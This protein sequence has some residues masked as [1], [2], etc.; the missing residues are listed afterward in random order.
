M[1]LLRFHPKSIKI[2]NT[3]L[4]LDVEESNYYIHKQKFSPENIIMHDILSNFIFT[5]KMHELKLIAADKVLS[6]ILSLSPEEYLTKIINKHTNTK[7]C[8]L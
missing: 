1:D 5:K 3:N 6:K 7:G 8:I 4:W 2:F